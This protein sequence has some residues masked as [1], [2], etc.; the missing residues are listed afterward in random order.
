M[1]FHYTEPQTQLEELFGG[2]F[3][4]NAIGNIE[5]GDAG[6]FRH[7]LTASNVPPRCVVYIDSAGGDVDA[8]IEI[9][10]LIRG[11]WLST[12]VG[13]YL[14]DFGKTIDVP[15]IPRKKHQG[16]CLSAATLMYLGGRLRYL[17]D[18]ATFGV[19]QFK[20]PS[21]RGDE[22]PKHFL[23]KS[24]NLSARISEY[25]YDM[26]ISPQFLLLSAATPSN[27]MRLV[28]KPELERIGVVTGGQTAVAWILEAN[29]GIS[30][31]KGERERFDL[32]TSQGNALLS[33]R[34][35]LL[36]LGGD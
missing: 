23:A 25:I 4:I 7:F 18:Q 3:C 31:V 33:Q 20:F 26:G 14:L 6:R 13:R 27:E 34:C 2:H 30:Y 29:N 22:V 5:A 8:A 21:A 10:R 1:Q 35:W 24:Q 32:R 28:S 11:A 12:D 9:G 17:D 19:H 16:Q 15:L 36:F